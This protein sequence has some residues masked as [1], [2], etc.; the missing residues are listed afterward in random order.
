MTMKGAPRGRV[1]I[2]HATDV[3]MV[4]LEKSTTLATEARLGLLALDQLGEQQLDRH[5]RAE[6]QMCRFDHH[7]HAAAPEH[8]LH[9]V[10]PRD[11]GTRGQ[12]L[13]SGL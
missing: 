9:A 8:L 13:R 3:R 2:H 4:R 6:L 5:A 12:R 7:P 11:D 1:H 10:L